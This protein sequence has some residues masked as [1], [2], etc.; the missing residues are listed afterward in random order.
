M[1]DA[2]VSTPRAAGSPPPAPLDVPCSF[3]LQ[4]DGRVR[5]E[6]A[7]RELVETMRGPHGPLWVDIDVTSRHQVAILEKV[8]GFHPLSIEDTLN[9]DSRVKVE[10]Y[11]GYLFVIIRG[12]RF[13]EETDDPYDLETF[14]LCFFLGPDYLVTVHGQHSRSIAAVRE[15]VE[16]TPDVLTRG[17]ARLMHDVMD[18]VVD[19][20]FPITDQI[21][22][23]VD[24]LEQ[25]VF[26]KF[27][28]TA[29]HDVFAVKR[30]VLSLRR[31]LAP[32]REVFNILTNRP[33]PLLP[34]ETQVYFRDVYDHVLRI[35]DSLETFRELLSSTMDS[36][37]NQVSNRLAQVT[38]GLSVVATLSIPFVVISGMWGMN[39]RH[40]PL[41]EWPHGFWFMLVL[42][43][44]LGAG[45]VALLRWRRLL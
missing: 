31:H 23:F 2:T 18:Q 15:R 35:N 44:A 11:P 40:I 28:E 37:L 43:L 13:Q 26:G 24:G 20:Y 10:E 36:Y 5:R 25:R 4:P 38:K 19:H 27:D 1:S 9:P 14:N 32:Q 33:T 34:G 7:P 45:L 39:F 17:P 42:Q 30:L 6:L 21:D 3:L 29:M 16:R 12:I 41:S 22:E 8:F